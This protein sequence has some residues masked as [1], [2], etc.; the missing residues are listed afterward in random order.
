M[1]TKKES[2]SASLKALEE[3]LS[4][5]D[6]QTEVDVEEGLKKVREGAALIGDLRGRLKEAENEF[7]ELKKALA[8]ED[9]S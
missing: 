1:P 6:G 3:L 8:A 9:A 4:W 5:F 7:V 2:I